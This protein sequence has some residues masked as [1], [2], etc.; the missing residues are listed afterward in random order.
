MGIDDALAA[1]HSADAVGKGRGGGALD[2]EPTDVHLQGAQEV[3]GLTQAGKHEDPAGG[4]TAAQRGHR[5]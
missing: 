5:R 3:T 4:V 1:G 2:D